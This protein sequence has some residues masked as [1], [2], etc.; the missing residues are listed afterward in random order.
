MKFSHY[1]AQD[2]VEE[3][4]D[5]INQDLN[6]FDDKGF[7]IASTNKERI[8]TFHEGAKKVLD[9]KKELIIEYDNQYKGA[10]KGINVP[11]Y[12]ENE[13]VGVIGITGEKDE[14]EQYGKIIQRITNILIKDGYIREQKK[15]EKENKRQFIEELLFRY[16]INEKS[17]LMWAGLLD[18]DVEINR[19]VMVVR[20]SNKDNSYDI[21]SPKITEKVYKS[22]KEIVSVN[23]QNLMI[24][25]GTNIIIIHKVVKEISTNKIAE[26]IIKKIE[27]KYRNIDLYIGIGT[28]TFC[29]DD[30]KKSYNEAKKALDIGYVVRRKKISKYTDLDIGLL[31]D[32]LSKEA[33]DEYINRI[34]RNLNEE[35]IK[36]YSH[37]L[38]SYINHNGSINKAADELFIHKNTLQYRLNKLES[39]TGYNPRNLRDMVVLYL[40][41]ILQR[42]V[43]FENL[44]SICNKN[45]LI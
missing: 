34:F 26:D 41:F 36:K 39:L 8:G 32:D 45:K 22:I 28:E 2:I 27:F 4:K 19:F 11:V 33:I 21:T 35:D 5:I 18:F 14:V 43:M 16:H 44:N 6:Y 13:V 7:I 30:I 29:L 12:F 25:F 38:A 23:N 10:K 37:M 1:L 17:L 24:Q 42:E 15:A 40:A 20:I 9:T 3:M 31:I